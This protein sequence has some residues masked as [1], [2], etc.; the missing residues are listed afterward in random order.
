MFIIAPFSAF[1][2]ALI[3]NMNRSSYLYAFSNVNESNFQELQ[4]RL[5]HKKVI[6]LPSNRFIRPMTSHKGRV[7]LQNWL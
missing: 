5:L 4:K 7:P 1:N 2:H 6:W 3:I